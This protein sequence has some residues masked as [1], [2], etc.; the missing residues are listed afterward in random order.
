MDDLTPHISI[1]YIVSLSQKHYEEIGFIPKPRLKKYLE[2]DQIW[3]SKENDDPCGFIIFGKG[4]PV[5]RIYQTCIQYDVRRQHHALN[6]IKKLINKAIAENYL[7]ISLWCAH[8]LDANQFW[9]SC[10]FQFMEQKEGGKRRHRK[11]NKWVLFLDNLF[12]RNG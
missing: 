11:L 2:S 8:E 12:V 1:D 4:W 3:L 5:L 10:G 9:Q 7:A 6:L